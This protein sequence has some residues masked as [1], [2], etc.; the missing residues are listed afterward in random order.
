MRRARRRAAAN[1]SPTTPLIPGT[2][3]KSQRFSKLRALYLS[4]IPGL[5]PIPRV[6]EA[7][8]RRRSAE[9]RRQRVS[10]SAGTTVAERMASLQAASNPHHQGQYHHLPPQPSRLQQVPY[11]AT[12]LSEHAETKMSFCWRRRRRICDEWRNGWSRWQKEGSSR[13]LDGLAHNRRHQFIATNLKHVAQPANDPQELPPTS[14]F[15]AE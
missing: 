11:E 13:L 7:M 14:R 6:P 1:N 8:E 2:S 9:S 12:L 10:L 4:N 5:V 15:P 3:T